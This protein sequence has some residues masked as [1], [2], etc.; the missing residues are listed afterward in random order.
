MLG[1]ETAAWS[2]D[3]KY[4]APGTFGPGKSAMIID[5]RTG[6]LVRKLDLTSFQVGRVAPSELEDPGIDLQPL[7]IRERGGYT[8]CA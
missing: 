6:A 3:G 1:I 7:V 8:G 2:P 5:A 4:I